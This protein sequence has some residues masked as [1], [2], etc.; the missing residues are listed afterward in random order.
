MIIKFLKHSSD[1][2]FAVLLYSLVV[3]N[4]KIFCVT[5]VTKHTASAMYKRAN[6]QYHPFADHFYS[7][8]SKTVLSFQV[9]FCLHGHFRLPCLHQ[10]H[11]FHQW[12]YHLLFSHNVWLSFPNF[13]CPFLHKILKTFLVISFI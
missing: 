3:F 7:L 12:Y 10:Y 8:L 6:C 5:D 2:L 11:L 1:D 13:H 9:I 4:S